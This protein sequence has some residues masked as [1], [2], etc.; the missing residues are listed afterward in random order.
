MSVK[1]LSLYFLGGVP[2]QYFGLDP[3]DPR[4]STIVKLLGLGLLI[5]IAIA[6]PR[7]LTI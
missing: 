7:E 4:S 6:R 5:G 1:E 3:I 2:I